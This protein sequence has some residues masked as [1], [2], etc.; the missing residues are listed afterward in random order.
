VL[1]VLTGVVPDVPRRSVRIAPPSGGPV[2]ALS[3]SG[4][5]LGTGQLDLS[6]DAAGHPVSVRAPMGITV[7]GR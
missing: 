3:V 2:G 4:L 5:R 1:R 7:A 6:L